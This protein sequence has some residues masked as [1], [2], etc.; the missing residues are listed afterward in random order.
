VEAFNVSALESGIEA[1]CFHRS[2][3]G[4][5]SRDVLF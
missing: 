5:C 4:P 2:D 3:G 1:A